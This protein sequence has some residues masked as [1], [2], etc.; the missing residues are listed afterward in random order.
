MSLRGRWTLFLLAACAAPSWAQPVP[1]EE[2][3]PELRPWTAWA[4]DGVPAAGC[5]SVGEAPVCVWP[6]HLALE[7]SESG[8][9]FHTSNSAPPPSDA[10]SASRF[11]EL[12]R[13]SGRHGAR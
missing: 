5:V 7:L 12:A 11:S 1:P 4:L 13:T 6:G 10:A 8:G 9:T 3:P 2:L